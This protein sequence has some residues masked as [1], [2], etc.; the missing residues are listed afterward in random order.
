MH[1][2]QMID[3]VQPSDRP[4]EW[5]R[6]FK[7]ALA[8]AAAFWLVSRGIPWV[9]SGIVSPTVMGREIKHPGQ[10][11]LNLAVLAMGLHF[12]CALLYAAIM[13]P[14]IHQFR[15]NTGWIAGLGLGIVL[16]LINLATF[17]L[18][19]DGA[20]YSREIPAL[21]AHVAFAVVFTGAYKGFVKRR[22]TLE[23]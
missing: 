6:G 1:T 9:A 5:A 12:A 7:V 19:G 17:T 20:P 22:A 21:V 2:A 10:I 23:P 13:M 4:V 8:I 16:Y 15:F 18:I 3:P 14:I 11:N